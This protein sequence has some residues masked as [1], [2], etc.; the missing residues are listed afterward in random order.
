[1]FIRLLLISWFIVCCSVQCLM[2]YLSFFVHSLFASKPFF[3]ILFGNFGWKWQILKWLVYFSFKCTS[4]FMKKI[5]S[6]RLTFFIYFF[7]FARL[8]SSSRRFT[9]NSTYK[10]VSL[11]SFTQKN[12]ISRVL[13]AIHVIYVLLSHEWEFLYT[14]ALYFFSAYINDTFFYKDHYLLVRDIF[15]PQNSSFFLN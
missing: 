7:A 12:I 6:R 1:M 15:I 4:H 10:P 13:R 8:T 9:W 5:W 3:Q 2:L 14:F 11:C